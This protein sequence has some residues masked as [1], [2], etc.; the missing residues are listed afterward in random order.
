MH[1]LGFHAQKNK[2]RISRATLSH[3]EKH[4]LKG[5]LG[6][7]K[8]GETGGIKQ[9]IIRMVQA[10][11]FLQGLGSESPPIQIKNHEGNA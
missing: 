5:E 8:G 10:Q 2:I 11:A 7:A 6:I 4:V 9:E 1:G 3:A